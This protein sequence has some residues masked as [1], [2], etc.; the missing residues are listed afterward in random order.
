[1]DAIVSLLDDASA[2]SVRALWAELEREHGLG[3]VARIVPYPHVSYHLAEDYDLARIGDTL[4][5]VAERAA[6]FTARV[7]GLG[8]FRASEPVLYLAIERNPALD[9]VHAAIWRELAVEGMEGVARE[10]SP[11]Y[12]GATWAPHVT[13]AQR[14]LTSATLESLLSAWSARDFRRD[15]SISA[16]TLLS[17][18]SGEV[19]YA[20][21]ERRELSG[22]GGR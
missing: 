3:E 14:D 7:T 16:L 1:M 8:A 5:R 11:L 12:E 19:A 9:A 17:R 22:G 21:I 18:R 15:V 2:Q 20:P 13:L 10:P 6:P 4:G